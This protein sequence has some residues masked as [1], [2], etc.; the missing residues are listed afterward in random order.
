[1]TTRSLTLAIL[2]ATAGFAQAQ[3]ADSCD[4]LD[5]ESVARLVGHP[6][7]KPA[8]RLR[9]HDTATVHT[10]V[11]KIEGD[12]PG[13]LEVSIRRAP[14]ASI[15]EQNIQEM[16]AAAPYVHPEVRAS[17]IPQLG[18]YAA[19][20]H[21]VSRDHASV[22]VMHGTVMVHLSA[23]QLNM[24]AKEQPAMVAAVKTILGVEAGA[25]VARAA[26]GKRPEL[27]A[28]NGGVVSP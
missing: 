21:S 13:T 4:Y 18:D 15:N 27:H 23:W 12:R 11:W 17:R 22:V 9:D 5:R 8:A 19:F 25:A 6:V 7:G 10:C 1:M 24:G 20:R 2:C 14:D 16:K 28:R 26:I 3:P